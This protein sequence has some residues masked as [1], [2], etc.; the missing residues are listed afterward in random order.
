M[1]DR[2]DW[3]IGRVIDYLGSTGELD[4]TVVVFLSDNGAEGTIVEAMPLRG[5]P[6]IEAFVAEH[7][8][9]GVD[10]LGGPPPPTP[11]TARAGRR[12]PPRRRGCTR[13]SP[14]RAESGWWA[15]S[16][17]RALPGRGRS[18]PRSPPL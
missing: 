6:E 12:P 2:M 10:S 14:P 1:V 18:A 16:P 4:N 13:P 8:D 11:G 3:N 9:N 5:P 7:C 17:G 15:L